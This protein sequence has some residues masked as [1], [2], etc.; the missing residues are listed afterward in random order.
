MDHI[1]TEVEFQRG[2]T[3]CSSPKRRV[4]IVRPIPVMAFRNSPAPL[5][6]QRRRAPPP[7]QT[8]LPQPSAP[9]LVAMRPP[10]PPPPRVVPV[11]RGLVELKYFQA[12]ED[13][14]RLRQHKTDI[15]RLIR[16]KECE[17]SRW[18]RLLDRQ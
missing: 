8:S 18:R 11:T 5:P 3:R 7:P 1:P 15:K 9:S 10:R 6:P 17:A 14:Q 12:Q 4:V 13:L 2:V 16:Q